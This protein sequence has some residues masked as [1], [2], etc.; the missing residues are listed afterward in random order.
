[1][2]VIS[3]NNSPLFPCSNEFSKLVAEEYL[4]FFDFTGMTLDQSLRY[5]ETS[6]LFCIISQSHLLSRECPE[7]CLQSDSFCYPNSICFV[8]LDETGSYTE[9]KREINMNWYSARNSKLESVQHRRVWPVIKSGGKVSFESFF[10]IFYYG[11]NMQL[12]FLS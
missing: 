3:V 12:N 11:E 2:V 6:L 9:N 1:M 7:L 4:K 10:L 8:S 5:D